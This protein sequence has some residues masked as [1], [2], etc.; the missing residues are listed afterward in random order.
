MAASTVKYRRVR[1]SHIRPPLRLSS[2][3]LTYQPPSLSFPTRESTKIHPR[4][5]IITS[6]SLH[7]KY[8]VAAAPTDEFTQSMEALEIRVRKALRNSTDPKETLK[9]IDTIQHLGISHH[10]EQDID[11]TLRGLCG[12]DAG[13]DLFATAL[14]FRL[15]RYNASIPCSS[16]VFKKFMDETGRFK[17]SIVRDTWG[18][19]SLY[20]ASYLGG[21]SDEDI[22][23]E[24]MQF[25]K[26]HLGRSLSLLSPDE[27][28]HV[29]RAL[30]LP[31]HL[32]MAR[33]EARDYIHEYETCS[34]HMPALLT[35]AKL[36]Y[37]MLQSLHQ[38]ELAEICR[39]WKELG[40]VDRLG[41]ARDK[42]SE[43]FLWTVGIFPE[44][45]Y[46]DCRIELTKTI[47]ILLVMD[48]MFDSY[49]SLDELVLFTEA[50]RRWD[51]DAMQELPEYMKI[52]YMALYNTTNEIAFRVQKQHGLT[53][54]SHLK[55]T[56][57]DIFEA[58]LEEAKWFNRGHTPSFE[59]YLEN[60]VISAGSY[61]ALVHSFFLMGDHLSNQNVSMLMNPYP[62]LFTVSGQ[63]LRLW[64]DLGT[65]TEEQ[66]RGDNASS[67]QC[68]MR[69]NNHLEE[70][71]AR[72][73]IKERIGKLWWELNSI[74]MASKSMPW[75]TM[76]A[77]LNVA[78]T[79]Q[80]IYEHGDDKSAYSVDD[81]VQA[82]LFQSFSNF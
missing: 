47:C 65:S 13:D 17:E 43:C 59:E 61:M 57:I 54:V 24:A 50:I 69:E 45:Y 63:I 28:R 8:W 39:W 74:A 18:L 56:W 71:E 36:D 6:V 25:T 46:S 31:R 75:S 19:L 10:F 82:L 34:N 37:D 73:Y 38:K 1:S 4:S 12:W 21:E 22:L 9:M 11:T 53:V 26:L 70:D 44:P 64:D 32:R 48:D 2:W 14:H 66:E 41:F 27:G 40:L 76:K 23:K 80:V 81:Y 42:P 3:P 68:Y 60:G 5:S 58:F 55:R 30:R 15:L 49:G 79:A 16:G 67:I 72:K 78:R 33:L 29:A 77:S 7:D 35:L 52:C 62:R 51:L 20:E